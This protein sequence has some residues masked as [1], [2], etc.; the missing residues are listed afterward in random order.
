MPPHKFQTYTVRDLERFS[1]VYLSERFG[2]DI[3]LPVDVE[4]L[5]EKSEG[6]D[7]DY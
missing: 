3:P 2:P 6:I 1:S 4:L 5:V 7:L